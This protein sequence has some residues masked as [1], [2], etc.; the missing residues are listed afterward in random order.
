[1]GFWTWSETP[2]EFQSVSFKITSALC[3]DKIYFS[4]A[5]HLFDFLEYDLTLDNMRLIASSTT[6]PMRCIGMSV[7]FDQ[8]SRVL[9]YFGGYVPSLG[10]HF[11]SDIYTYRVD[12]CTWKKLEMDGQQPQPRAYHSAVSLGNQMYIFGGFDNTLYHLDDLWIAHFGFN[13]RAAWSKPSVRGMLPP[14]LSQASLNFLDGHLV[15]L[16]GYDG[17][18]VQED[19][20]IF[21]PRTLEWKS[22][23]HCEVESRGAGPTRAKGHQAITKSHICLLSCDSAT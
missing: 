22:S 9:I 16:G 15:L 8:R 11:I 1:M 6:V 20:H 18:E 13:L 21:S 23:S 4:R 2:T 7:V 17:T 5:S 14:G 10:G 3:N 19:L 12:S